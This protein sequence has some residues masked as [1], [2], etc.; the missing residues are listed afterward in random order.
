MTLV[1]EDKKIKVNINKRL[2][3]RAVISKSLYW[4]TTFYRIDQVEKKDEVIFYFDPID[5]SDLKA[6]LQKIQ[7]TFIDFNLREV[8][9]DETKTIRELIIAKAFYPVEG[10]A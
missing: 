6:D 2:Y 7:T 4:L 9:N 8:I 10:K 1:V 3:S 5:K